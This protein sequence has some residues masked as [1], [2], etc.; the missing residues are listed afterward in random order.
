M[1][2]CSWNQQPNPSIAL[3]SSLITCPC[4]LSS[5]KDLSRSASASRAQRAACHGLLGGLSVRSLTASAAVSHAEHTAAC[6][7][8]RSIS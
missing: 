7:A 8:K 1:S 2:R 3:A 5:W 4:W 6:L